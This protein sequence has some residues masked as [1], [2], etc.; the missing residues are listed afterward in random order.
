[1]AAFVAVL[2][3][4]N[5]AS[6]AKIIA[7]PI[8]L[9]SFQLSFDAG[10][11]LFP[12]SYIFGDI[13][14]EVY[15][16]RRSRRVIW[17]GF[18]ALALSAAF[19]ALV[20]ALPGDA[21]WQKSAGQSA[22]DAILG[23]LS[24]GGIVVA[25]LAAFFAGEF[26]NSIILARLKVLTAGRLL[27]LRT[28]SST[29][30]GQAL[31]SFLFTFVACLTGVFPWESFWSISIANY[32]FKTLIEVIMTPATYAVVNYLKKVESEDFFDRDTNFNPFTTA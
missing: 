29:L 26:S 19:F 16:Y 25:S 22:Y 28:I 15:G 24:S 11:L 10:T 8:T 4:S 27:W 18:G 6:S 9:G 20:R 7:W 30:V 12:L 31:D 5:I 32:L 21:I 13:L 2:L 3:S 17:T 14:T 1:M 23:G